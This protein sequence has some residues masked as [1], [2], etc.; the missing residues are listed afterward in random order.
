M[1]AASVSLGT[2]EALGLFALTFAVAWRASRSTGGALGEVERAKDVL[3]HALKDERADHQRTK[4]TMGAEIR[5]LRV[6]VSALQA[7]TDVAMAIEA[8]G[9][10]HE[11]RAQQRHEGLV[12][13]LDLI[14]KRL[15]KDDDDG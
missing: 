7:R 9:A 14:A 15:G 12:V 4:D 3:E 6:Q 2:L 5:D 11:E 8:W 10:G 13:V 1:L